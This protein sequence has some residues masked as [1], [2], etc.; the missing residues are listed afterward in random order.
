MEMEKALQE[1]GM[2]PQEARRVANIVQGA[3]QDELLYMM[4]FLAGIKIGME[5]E[6][7]RKQSK[8]KTK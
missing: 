2:M 4:I 5:V 7:R 1:L 8:R 3:N 6:R